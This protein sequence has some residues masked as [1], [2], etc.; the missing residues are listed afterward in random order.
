M[1]EKKY[2]VIMKQYISQICTLWLSCGHIYV[3]HT[4]YKHS[5][6]TYSTILLQKFESLF[7]RTTFIGI[8]GL[9]VG[10]LASNTDRNV[11]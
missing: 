10:Y 2:M 4:V 5:D 3:M 6:V 11:L 7:D 1:K 9:L 8:C